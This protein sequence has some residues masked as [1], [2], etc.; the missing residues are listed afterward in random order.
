MVKDESLNLPS[1]FM[2]IT[3]QLSVM[4]LMAEL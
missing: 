2:S 4:S 1:E 3:T